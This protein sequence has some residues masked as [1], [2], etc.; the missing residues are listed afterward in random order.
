VIKA[1]FFDWFNTLAYYDPPREELHS[2][3]LGEFG[4]KISPAELK[5][6]LLAADKHFFDEI[7]DSSTDRNSP[8]EKA[9]IYI[10][11][12]KM[13]L[14]AVGIKADRELILHILN[15]WPQTFGQAHF[16]L[17]DDVLDTM[18]TLKQRNFVLGL[19]TNLT[20][21]VD[22]FSQELGVGP[23][24][25]FIVNPKEVG[26][27]KPQPQ[28]FLAA[29]ERA[30]VS[31]S[32]AVHVGDQYKIDVVGARGVGINPILIDRY[33]L[34]PEVTDCPRIRDLTGLAGYL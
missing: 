4:I 3:L 25:D 22:S 21:G 17:F 14:S 26:A 7:A 29:L 33:D 24:L 30:E 9:E 16:A 27:D 32:E 18:R 1:V 31:A 10:Y 6:G 20:N 2:R 19:L 5:P 23:Y 12:T 8:K 11:Y 28:I 15:K 34:Y 13:M